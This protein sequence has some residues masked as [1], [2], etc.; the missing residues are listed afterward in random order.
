MAN[1]VSVV[2]L[3]AGRGADLEV[4]DNLGNRP[5]G[6]AASF[7]SAKCANVL[8]RAGANPNILSEYDGLTPPM[9][10][11]ALGHFRTASEFLKFGPVDYGQMAGRPC[12]SGG[13]PPV[14][15]LPITNFVRRTALEIAQKTIKKSGYAKLATVFLLQQDQGNKG[16]A[17]GALGF[18]LTDDDGGEHGIEEHECV[19][20]AHTSGSNAVEALD[21]NKE[22]VQG[23]L[24]FNSLPVLEHSGSVQREPKSTC[25]DRKAA[26]R[27]LFIVQ[28]ILEMKKAAALH[29]QSAKY[30]TPTYA[31]TQRREWDVGGWL[32]EFVELRI[33]VTGVEDSPIELCVCQDELEGDPSLVPSMGMVRKKDMS[34]RLWHVCICI[35]YC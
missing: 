25:G 1:K 34:K 7:D 3:L 24:C 14:W 13:A 10:A 12:N 20:T 27:S 28:A 16:G 8:L 26:N 2:K 9:K 29:Q 17:A 33:K 22:L 6:L 5:L 32:E 19:E 11:A 23:E 30:D 18:L 21:Q 15:E 31:I 35:G 4:V